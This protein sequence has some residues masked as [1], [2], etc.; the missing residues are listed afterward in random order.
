MI[1]LKT[2]ESI[3]IEAALLLKASILL[4]VLCKL[5]KCFNILLSNEKGHLY[6]FFK[7]R[8]H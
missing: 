6:I 5:K 7:S 4:P 2:R 1:N 3:S 8:L